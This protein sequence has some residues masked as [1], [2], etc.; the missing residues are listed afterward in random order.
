MTRQIV[1][2]DI[3]DGM[4]LDGVL[5]SAVRGGTYSAFVLAR[6]GTAPYTYTLTAGESALAAA[7]IALNRNTGEVASANVLTAGKFAI[8]IRA[9]D[10]TG[11]WVERS[12]VLAVVG[13]SPMSVTRQDNAEHEVYTRRYVTTGGT[14][15]Y[16]ASIIAGALPDG[17][18]MTEDGVLTGWYTGSED[19]AW[20]VD[21]V[22]SIGQHATLDDSLTNSRT[23][24][25]VYVANSTS[26]EIYFYNPS[27][28]D[29]GSI[30][31]GSWPSALAANAAGDTIYCTDLSDNTVSFIYPSGVPSDV[32]NVGDT[33]VDVCV[34]NDGA[35][36][37][38]A[39]AN[40][41]SVSVISSS[42]PANVSSFLVGSNPSAI[43]VNPVTGDLYIADGTDS[44]VYIRDS[45][46][47]GL[48][49]VPVMFPKGVTISSSGAHFFVCGYDGLSIFDVATKSL[50]GVVTL[51][52]GRS[53]T[54]LELSRDE[55][56][57]F[58][59]FNA[60]DNLNV[61][62]VTDKSAPVVIATV[63]MGGPQGG[64]AADPNVDDM[65]VSLA[66]GGVL[67]VHAD[68]LFDVSFL[69]DN[70]DGGIV[71]VPL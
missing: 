32:A 69:G 8:T 41:G 33:P 58:V 46:G 17:V 22:D 52:D 55:R 27:S 50:T 70:G 11:A 42:D 28:S 29:Q 65:Y 4:A 10:I 35:Y 56:Y 26:G 5:P 61:V 40:S 68:G 25:Q 54:A 18:T 20:T 14:P 51:G 16:V 57:V 49:S 38:C 34:S 19:F 66:S 48:D 2:I 60:Q 24:S 43:R 6:G 67:T 9:T 15:P 59:V 12:F 53:P 13:S 7:G 63:E 31:A 30:S 3:G 62:D 64:I 21:V 36:V 37:Y 39:N 71:V 44:K 47:S 45:Y 23:I 1:L